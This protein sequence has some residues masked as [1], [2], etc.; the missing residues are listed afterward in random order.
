[1][2]AELEGGIREA[3]RAVRD[4]KIEHIYLLDSDGIELW[5][6]T[7]T[8]RE[9][10][11]ERVARTHAT[12]HNHPSGDPE[13]SYADLEFACVR[14]I[15]VSVTVGKTGIAFLSQPKNGWPKMD[16]ERAHIAFM[17]YQHRG[18]GPA[19]VVLGARYMVISLEA[20]MSRT[21]FVVGRHSTQDLRRLCESV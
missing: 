19:A 13:M 8:R 1:M 9:V 3:V 16:A 6:G 20:F 2:K 17:Q 5:S 12:V 10:V 18:M 7:G 15:P 21:R 4:Q 11:S 14:N